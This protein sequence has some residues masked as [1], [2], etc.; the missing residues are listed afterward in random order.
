MIRKLL[1]GD[2]A[3][4]KLLRFGL[5]GGVS[6]LLYGVCA[7]GLIRWLAFSPIAASIAAYLLAIPANFVMQRQ[8]A[9]RSGGRVQTEAPRFL[10]VHGTNI[11]GSTGIMHATVDIFHLDPFLG[12]VA[13]MMVIPLLS[14]MVM[15]LWVFPVSRSGDQK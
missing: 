11:L 7:W 13:T 12:I 14:F 15:H 9:F 6:S 3:L 2:F 8:F 5:I 10:L 4:A 1:T